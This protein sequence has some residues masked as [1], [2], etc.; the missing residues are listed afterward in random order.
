MGTSVSGNRE[1][2]LL[3]EA[4][5]AMESRF[6]VRERPSLLLSKSV[7]VELPDNEIN[8][9]LDVFRRLLRGELDDLDVDPGV[10]IYHH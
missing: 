2:Q 9:G 4:C 5:D 6:V 10:H 7:P 3:V 8:I 1:A